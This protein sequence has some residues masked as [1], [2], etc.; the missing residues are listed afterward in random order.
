[1][2]HR[3]VE[4]DDGPT[5]TALRAFRDGY[6]QETAERRALV[7]RYYEMAPRIVAA[8]PRDHADWAWIGERVD[9]AIAAIGA[10]EDERAFATYVDMVRR[11][12][13]RWLGAAF[14]GVP[15]SGAAS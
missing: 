5:L 7:A 8:I 15:L 10:G 6:M 4:A 11:L 2:D 3:G 13:A 1:M 14:Q 9:A 12:E